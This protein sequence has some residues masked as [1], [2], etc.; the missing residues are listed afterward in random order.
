MSD[1]NIPSQINPADLSFDDVF[2]TFQNDTSSA[3][4]APQAPASVTLPAPQVPSEPFL[5]M[6]T[7][8]VYQTREDAERG[9]AEKDR[10]IEQS[11][12][13]TIAATGYDPVTG[14]PV[15]IHANTPDPSYA[16]NPEKYYDDLAAA[17]N[18]GDKREFTRIQ[19]KF[20]QDTYGPLL[21]TTA[22]SA[23]IQDLERTIKTDKG[24]Q[25][26][27]E[28]DQYRG[29]LDSTP[30]MKQA[31]E[32]AENSVGA[33]PQ[34]RD[35]YAIAYEASQ[36]RNIAQIIAQNRVNTTTPAP[37]G[38][39]TTAQTSF[40]PTLTPSTPSMPSSATNAAPSLSTP[41]GRRAILDSGRAVGLDKLM[42]NTVFSSF[43]Q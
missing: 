25:T 33:A 17:N 3:A 10:V 40:R 42:G 43:G 21:T 13:A 14:K 34:L 23:A 11:R 7:G 6:P 28:S 1:S 37:Q 15:N 18:K 8:T 2:D 24:F 39:N 4:A 20:L 12:A 9:F 29:Y 31:I 32:M 30:I 22:K 35:L 16:T 26:F 5:R 36:G 27:L 19:Q 41:E 38:T